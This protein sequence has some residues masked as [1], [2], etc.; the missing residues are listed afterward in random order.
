M[1]NMIPGKINL[2]PRGPRLNHTKDQRVGQV[3]GVDNRS[4]NN[5]Q[6]LD[7]LQVYIRG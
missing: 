7:D 5:K 2:S 1:E 3:Y 6:L 4:L